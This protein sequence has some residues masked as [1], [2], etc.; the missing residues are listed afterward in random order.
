MLMGCFSFYEKNELDVECLEKLLIFF[1]KSRNSFFIFSLSVNLRDVLEKAVDS[2]PLP[3]PTVFEYI[4]VL[5]REYLPHKAGEPN[6][7]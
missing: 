2:F 3:S 5:L 6:L 7:P 4:N 1:K